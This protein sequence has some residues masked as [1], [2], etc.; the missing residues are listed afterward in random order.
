VVLL[1]IAFGFGTALILAFVANHLALR[2]WRQSAGQHWTERARQLYPARASATL[3]LV[4]IPMLLFVAG[5]LVFRGKFAA[6]II[7]AAIPGVVLGNYAL[8]RE[9]YPQLKLRGWISL[10]VVGVI[11]QAGFWIVPLIMAFLLP[12]V[13]GNTSILL[14]AGT[15]AFGAFSAAEGS[16]PLLRCFRM[17]HTAP[18]SVDSLARK[19]AAEKGIQ[20]KEIWVLD[21]PISNAF[22]SLFRRGLGFTSRLLELCPEPELAA[23]IEHELGHLT[24][25]RW[26]RAGRF[27][28]HFVLYP[29]LFFGPATHAFGFFGLLGL[30]LLSLGLL[31]FRQ[32]LLRRMENRADS[33]AI[34]GASEGITYATALSRLY[35][36]NQM[37]AVMPKKARMTHPDLYDRILAAGVTPDYPRPNPPAARAWTGRVMTGMFIAAVVARILMDMNA[38]STARQQENDQQPPAAADRS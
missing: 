6:T 28:T 30:V 32:W 9:I 10:M 25:S 11:F 12:P 19:L 38:D 15:F 20:I 17:L 31:R 16:I 3:N 33:H 36:T 5:S 24:E 29:I 27:M 22:A 23:I 2:P 13:F 26:A 35:E 1:E 7:C 37:P 18:A 4:V 8:N 21:V 34:A 14:L